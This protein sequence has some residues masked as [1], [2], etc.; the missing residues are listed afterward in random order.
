[1]NNQYKY[2]NKRF[3]NNAGQ[4]GFIVKYVN[5]EN[6]YF[7]FDS[8]YVGCFKLHTIKKGDF[9]D[10]M[11][12]SLYGVGFV[13]DG[14]HKPSK[15]GK[16]T[17]AYATWARMLERCYYEKY[18]ARNPTYIG[19]T[20]DKE[21]HNFQ[22]FAKWYHENYPADGKDYQLDKDL[23]VKGNKIYSADT[24][25]FLTPQQ[26][27]E[28]SQAKRYQFVSP[29]GDKVTVFNLRRFCRENN[30]NASHMAQVALGKENQHKGWTIALAYQ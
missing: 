4:S 7:Q 1:M 26:N 30:L 14:N 6:V 8:G 25:C 15:N 9:K 3:T 24:C 28:T 12:P 2:L 27:T 20:V 13:G 10:K 23:L 22:C 5:C 21:W 19:C 16:N 29:N 11:S 17:K 18:Q